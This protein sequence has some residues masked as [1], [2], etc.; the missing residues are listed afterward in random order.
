V[1]SRAHADGKLLDLYFNGEPS[2]RMKARE[3]SLRAVAAHPG[4][5]KTESTR[6]MGT[7]VHF[8][9][10]FPFQ[11]VAM[12][13]LPSQRVAYDANALSGDCFGSSGFV[14]GADDSVRVNSNT[15]SHGRDSARRL[16]E[17]SDKATGA[18]Y[19]RNEI[20]DQERQRLQVFRIELEGLCEW[21]FVGE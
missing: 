1:T 16:W 12:G 2:R 7:T 10:R 13:A 19:C 6:Q 21:L 18:W 17:F 15:R 14:E 8:F 5:T 20:S 3:R 11:D 9:P 4:A